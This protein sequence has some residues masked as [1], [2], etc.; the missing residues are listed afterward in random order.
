MQILKL[1]LIASGGNCFLVTI[2]YELS[3]HLWFA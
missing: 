2:Y 1:S 3:L